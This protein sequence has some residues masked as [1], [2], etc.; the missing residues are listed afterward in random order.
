M[1]TNKDFANY[2]CELLASAGPCVA[3]RMFGGWGISTDGLTIA[4]I[5]SLGGPE[6]LWLKASDDTRGQFEAAGC[7]RFSYDMSKNGEKVPRSMNYY[8]APE[9]AMES[10]DAMRS[11][12]RLALECA[13]TGALEKARPMAAG[14]ASKKASK[15]ATMPDRKAQPATKKIEK[16]KP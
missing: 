6:R 1:P 7:A 2:C 13:L 14:K 12:A 4:I 9:D 8:S 16:K 5:A 11:W 3:K 15:V 10:P